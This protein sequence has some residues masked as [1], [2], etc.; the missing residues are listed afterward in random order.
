[1]A[2]P[3][4]EIWTRRR[5]GGAVLALLLVP[6]LSSANPQPLKPMVEVWKSPSCGCCKVWVQHLEASGFEV[7]V[8]DVGN[9]AVRTRLGIP[10][11]LGSCHTAKVGPYAV[12]G[13]VPARE[14]HRLL[15]EKPDAVGLAVPGM[16]IGSP[17][18]DGPK[19]G[20]RRDPYVVLLV[21]K[22]G[23]TYPFQTYR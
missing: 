6:S 1:M 17:G 11:K 21:R 18:M 3:S 10:V 2:T 7:T 16:P 23:S 4:P 20:P 22:D 19:Y 5:A 12:E 8:H 15:K 9:T 14:L 13:H